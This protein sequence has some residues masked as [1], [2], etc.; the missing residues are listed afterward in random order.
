MHTIRLRGPWKL[1][2]IERFVLR[3]DGSHCPTSDQLPSATLA[4]MPADWSEMLEECFL[5]VVRYSR[6][7]NRPTNLEPHERVWLVVEPPRSH[8]RVCANDVELG[9]VRLG[10]PA[11]RF[12]ITALLKDYNAVVIDVGH[13]E[14]D[15]EGQAIGDGSLSEAGGLV[16]EVRLEIE[17]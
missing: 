3:P 9:C 16:G 15:G 11:G 5:G 13:P 2:A 14:L 8:G 6:N 7:F 4:K 12:D 17:D 10:A 1:Q